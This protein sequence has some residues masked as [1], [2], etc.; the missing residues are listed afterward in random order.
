M[1]PFVYFFAALFLLFIGNLIFR[2]C[3]PEDLLSDS[4]LEESDL[5]VRCKPGRLNKL[6]KVT[7]FNKQEIRKLYQGFKQECPSGLVTEEAFKAIFAHYFPQG[8]SSIYAHYVFKTFQNAAGN[9]GRLNFEILGVP[10]IDAPVEATQEA[11]NRYEKYALFFRTLLHGFRQYGQGKDQYS[12][13]KDVTLSTSSLHANLPFD[14]KNWSIRL[15]SAVNFV[16]F[17]SLIFIKDEATLI[18]LGDNVFRSKDRISIYYDYVRTHGFNSSHLKM[19]TA[20]TKQFQLTVHF[21]LNLYNRIITCM[22]PFIA[23]LYN[24][25]FFTNPYTYQISSLAIYGTLWSFTHTWS[26]VFLANEMLTTS[27]YMF[28][29]CAIHYY[30]IQSV[31]EQSKSIPNESNLSI[32]PHNDTYIANDDFKEYRELKSRDKT[33]GTM[34]RRV[35]RSKV[36]QTCSS[37]SFLS[38]IHRDIEIIAN[39]DLKC[40]QFTPNYEIIVNW[41]TN[42]IGNWTHRFNIYEFDFKR[43]RYLVLY[44]FTVVAFM[45]DLF[46]FLGVIIVAHSRLVANMYAVLGLLVLTLSAIGCYFVGDFMT[47]LETLHRR[48]HSICCETRLPINIR[49]KILEIMDR[50]LGPYNG[51]KVGD[52]AT[53]TQSFFIIFMLEIAATFMLFV[54]N[55]RGL[56][57]Q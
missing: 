46:I 21:L 47:K 36:S 56:F 31:V 38:T 12:N 5:Y 33:D 29:I 27:G 32:G 14:L 20:Q 45:A 2:A 51:I 40:A 4:D 6:C 57:E 44:Y 54:C 34:F 50:S 28:L 17:V 52:L 25:P 23:I 30:R 18:Y 43:L 42:L 9:K 7:K 39:H 1:S 15:A 53:I 24:I 49:L 22:V 8:D 19:T 16:R 37:E 11:I 13:S 10:K 48:F 55:I 41:A 26:V 3:F 35:K